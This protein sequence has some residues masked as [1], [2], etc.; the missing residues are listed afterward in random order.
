MY[1]VETFLTAIKGKEEDVEKEL[2]R[3]VPLS[4]TEKGNTIFIAHRSHEDP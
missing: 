4:R 1:T 3:I 2:L